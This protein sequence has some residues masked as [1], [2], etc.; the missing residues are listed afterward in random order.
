MRAK[1][2]LAA[3]LVMAC[4]VPATSAHAADPV[5]DWTATTAGWN[6]S[7]SP[8]IADINGDGVSDIVVGHEDG[9]RPRLRRRR[10]RTP[11]LA[12]TGDHERVLG[13]TAID[14]SPAV[15]DLNH[16]GRP[17]IVVGVGS[18]FQTNH[19][20]GVIVFRNDGSIQCRFRDQGHVQHVDGRRTRRLLRRR[21]LHSRDR[22]RQRRRRLPTSSSG[23]GTTTCTRST[24]TATRSRGFPYNVDDTIFSSPALYD[25]DHDGRM[26]IFIGN[27][28]LGNA[29][30]LR[31]RVPRARLAERRGTP[32]VEPQGSPT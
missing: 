3:T 24:A 20:G 9:Y 2:L 12:A 23:A 15:G 1:W 21:V 4:V 7:S 27:D 26:E 17:E 18:V 29:V 11:A 25:V 5:A 30:V 31:R 6:R 28:Y 13:R 22:R 10:A 14:G 32:A 8:V 16:D 19:H